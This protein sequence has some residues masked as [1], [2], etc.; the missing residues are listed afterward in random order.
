[1][2]MRDDHPSRG[3]AG[4]QPRR[5][6]PGSHRD[7]PLPGHLVLAVRPLSKRCGLFCEYTGQDSPIRRAS[8]IYSHI[9][10]HFFFREGGLGF[11]SQ[12]VAYTWLGKSGFGG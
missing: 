11:F 6:P 2:M 8:L 1:M 3:L 4:V 10:T 9:Y 12:V 5:H 7:L